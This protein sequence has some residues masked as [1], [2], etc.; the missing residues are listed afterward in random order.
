LRAGAGHHRSFSIVPGRTQ[1][2]TIH[3]PST[4]KRTYEYFVISVMDLF[5]VSDE[6]QK[7]EAARKLGGVAPPS[8]H[9]ERSNRFTGDT[10][11]DP[12]RGQFSL[13]AL[14]EV[15]TAIRRGGTIPEEVSMEFEASWTKD[16]L[17]KIIV[18]L[19]YPEAI[20]KKERPETFG[21]LLEGIPP[22]TAT[23]IANRC[24]EAVRHL[25]EERFRIPPSTIESYIHLDQT[26]TQVY[27]IGVRRWLS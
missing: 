4:R 17:K 23:A 10:D 6:E 27:G 11:A 20:E 18:H 22:P 9:D 15:A 2:V 19:E 5:E 7:A 12:F 26:G 21:R 24:V 8:R 16:K 1:T 3:T 13:G 14:Y 25:A